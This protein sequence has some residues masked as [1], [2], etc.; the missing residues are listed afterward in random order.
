MKI[1]DVS[2]VY[3][4]W[5]HAGAPG[6]WQRH[7][8]QIVVRVETDVGVAG[9]GYGGG[10]PPGVA[11]VNTHLRE[12]LLGRRVDSVDD[13]RAAWDALYAASIPYGRKG[14]AVMA[15]SGVDLALWDMLGKAEGKPVNELIGPRVRERVRAYASGHD[16]E[17]YAELGITAH[18]FSGRWEG[19]EPRYDDVVANAAL[20]R[21]FLGTDALVMIDA[22]MG[23]D[24]EVA[25]EMAWRLK[26]FDIY[27]FEDLFTPDEL[28]AQAALRD[29]I[30]PVLV[31]GG[32]HEFTR[33]GFADIARVGALGLWQPD[34]TWCGGITEGLRIVE[35]AAEHRV[36]VVPHRGGEI[37]GLQLIV[38][39]G[40][41]DLAE[42]L[43]VGRDA[44]RDE[45]WLGEPEIEDGYVAPSDRPGFGVTLNEA[46]L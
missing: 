15:L 25:I 17:W 45:L 11:V 31:A 36:P 29:E 30:K 46:M 3:P 44:P 43:R 38:S 19:D 7:F 10:G 20:A 21:R 28:E 24:A 16:P 42:W 18:K 34:V 32:E 12:L 40:C 27:W 33:H 23:W 2:A 39:S 26:E 9:L 8:W 37:W 4:K 35:L 6:R 41:D 22:Y 14:L 5:R 13:I 1:T